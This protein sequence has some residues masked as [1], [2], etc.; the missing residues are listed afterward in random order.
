M[1]LHFILIVGAIGCA[2]MAI[3]SKPLTA[4]LWLAGLSAIVAIL[5]YLFN[6]PEV[7]VVELSVGAGLITVLLAFAI[8]MAEDESMPASLVPRPAAWFL[9]IVAGGSLLWLIIPEV[10]VVSIE[11]VV[12]IPFVAH[13]WESRLL[14]LFVQIAIILAGVIGVLSLLGEVEPEEISDLAQP[15]KSG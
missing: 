9:I 3:R 7:A 8:S 14:D 12:D 2:V 5:L 1:A 6:A 4:A 13:I 11:P 10:S 15:E